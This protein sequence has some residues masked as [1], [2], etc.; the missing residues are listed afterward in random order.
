MVPCFTFIKCEPILVKTDELL[1]KLF[2]SVCL[3][4]LF[5]TYYS[6]TNDR[7]SML[8]NSIGFESGLF[9][10]WGFQNSNPYPL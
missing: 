6:K 5:N 3:G 4:F 1:K 7:I 10:Q 8:V 2:K 9:L